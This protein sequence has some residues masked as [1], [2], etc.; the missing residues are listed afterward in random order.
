MPSDEPKTD[1]ELLK[2]FADGGDHA[3]FAALVKRHGPMVHAVSMRVLSNHHDAQDVTQAAFLVLARRAAKLGRQSSV[4]GW[5]HTVSRRLSLN[6]RRS[7][8]SRQRREH[9]AMNEPTSN[10]PDAA[11]SA[12]F[13]RELDAA[14][15]RLPDSYR[16]PL[17]LFHLE[18]AS[19]KEAASRLDLHPT[20]LT[21]L[22]E[23]EATLVSAVVIALAA[24]GIAVHQ[25]DGVEETSPAA[26]ARQ[27]QATGFQNDRDRMGTREKTDP[28]SRITS[29]DEFNALVESVLLI[30]DDVERLAA[31]RERLGLEISDQQYREA[32]AAYGYQ[33]A[34]MMLYREL[35]SVWL[36]DDPRAVVL[37]AR[38]FSGGYG[39]EV[40]RRLLAGWLLTDE[41]AAMA[42]VDSADL[43][44]ELVAAAGEDA[45]TLRQKAGSLHQLP[46]TSAE[47]TVMSRNLH[48]GIRASQASGREA[49]LE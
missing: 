27:A 17:V 18:G 5:L 16:Q 35:M 8:E 7:R 21:I 2:R 22:M 39:T 42:W 33:M 13:R 40:K 26:N 28:L 46:E 47:A 3:A 6:A 10:V 34:P 49:A 29:R 23:T 38:R 44:H 36:R 43:D 31:I 41:S 9:A 20:T 14:L 24:V 15:E 1:A 25:R 11:L 4:A 32:L 37:W 48:D 12:G 45:E 30:G 19:L